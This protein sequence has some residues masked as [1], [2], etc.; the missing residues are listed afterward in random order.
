MYGPL[1]EPLA[2]TSLIHPILSAPGLR[3]SIHPGPRLGECLG[4]EQT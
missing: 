3:Q 1:P 4:I 2:L